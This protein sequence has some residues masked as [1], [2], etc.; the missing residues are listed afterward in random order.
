M[1]LHTH[2]AALTHDQRLRTEVCNYKYTSMKICCLPT[3]HIH[4]PTQVHSEVSYIR[5]VTV[6]V[7][8]TVNLLKRT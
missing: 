4:I 7:T 3:Q 1:Y 6:T 5:T 2:K 8:V